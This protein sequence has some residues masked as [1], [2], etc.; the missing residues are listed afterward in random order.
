MGWAGREGKSIEAPLRYNWNN[1]I[2]EYWNDDLEEI[3]L[4]F[5]EI[6]PTGLIADNWKHGFK[7]PLRH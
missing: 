1:G 2:M 6:F 4:N 3:I 7:I 5:R